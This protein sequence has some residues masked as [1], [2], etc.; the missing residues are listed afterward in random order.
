MIN[1]YA[2]GISANVLSI[3]ESQGLPVKRSLDI[4]I[5]P[6]PTDI[7]QVDDQELMTMASKYLQ[8]YNFMLTQV[9]CAELAVVEAESNYNRAEAKAMLSKSTGKS[10]EK[11]IMLK[12]QVSSDPEMI[13]L[14]DTLA[15]ANAYHKLLK[16]MQEDLERCYQLTSRELTRRTSVLK[17]RGY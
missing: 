3:L 13:A 17:A 5:P 9:A 8:N 6:L 7:T 15:H 4:D 14:E 10:T 2:E 12:A 11:S 1:L 16:T